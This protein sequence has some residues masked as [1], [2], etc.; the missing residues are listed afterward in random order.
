MVNLSSFFNYVS[1]YGLEKKY[2]RKIISSYPDEIQKTL[3]SY[4][5]FGLLN[6]R[7][8]NFNSFLN[9]LKESDNKYRYNIII[10]I[11]NKDTFIFL[12]PISIWINLKD[13]NWY[14]NLLKTL[15]IDNIKV[16]NGTTIKDMGREELCEHT[17]FVSDINKHYEKIIPMKYKVD[18]KSYINQFY[19]NFLQNFNDRVVNYF[20]NI[21]RNEDLLEKVNRNLIDRDLVQLFME[22]SKDREVYKSLL[23]NVKDNF[24]KHF[25]ENYIN[26]NYEKYFEN[27]RRYFIHNVIPNIKILLLML[28]ETHEKYV[29]YKQNINRHNNLEI[30]LSKN[31]NFNFWNH[32]I[33]KLKVIEYEK[34]IFNILNGN[35]KE[36]DKENYV[37]FSK[38][39]KVNDQGLFEDLE[40]NLKDVKLVN[41]SGTDNHIYTNYNTTGYMNSLSNLKLHQNDLYRFLLKSGFLLKSNPLNQN[42]PDIIKE[43]V[44][45]YD[46][47][48]YIKKLSDNKD[49]KIF[50]VI[51]YNKEGYI[52]KNNVI[53]VDK[54]TPDS[55]INFENSKIYFTVSQKKYEIDPI[56]GEWRILDGTKIKEGNGKISEYI[57]KNNVHYF[58]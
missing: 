36:Y 43:R 46:L 54:K 39:L 49:K 1:E 45:K 12:T 52:T 55:R 34:N 40:K 38:N 19:N 25:C 8:S 33:N 41:T 51:P 5:K 30:L 22:S 4:F 37:N 6:V 42:L 58:I 10:Q 57:A 14:E 13:E 21:N 56:T 28:K 2:N 17:Y 18:N 47:N 32:F 24:F 3:L 48:D 31:D 9:M 11:F 29:N 53:E 7:V 35:F 44:N 50:V 15:K 27:L 20:T 16:Q 26:E 23:P